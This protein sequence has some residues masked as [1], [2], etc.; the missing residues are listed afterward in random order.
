MP[1]GNVLTKVLAADRG[2]FFEEFDADVAVI[3]FD[4]DHVVS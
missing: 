2:F 4:S 1:V 3:G